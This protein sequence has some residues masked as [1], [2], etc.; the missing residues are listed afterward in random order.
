MVT[1]SLIT[2]PTVVNVYFTVT[3]S[4]GTDVASCSFTIYPAPV[5]APYY[6]PNP[7]CSGFPYTLYSG[8]T[9]GCPGETYT[10]SWTGLGG[11]SAGYDPVHRP[12]V[13]VAWGISIPYNITVTNITAAALPG[14]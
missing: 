12:A 1:S 2:C 14:S 8:V 3:N 10:Y 4:C 11:F 7:L 9:P 13:S 6:D 5:I